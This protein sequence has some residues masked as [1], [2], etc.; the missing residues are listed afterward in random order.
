MKKHVTP[1]TVL[2]ALALFFS[3]AGAG[4]AASSFLVTRLSQISPR[5]RAE[6]RGA[7]GPRGPAGAPGQPGAD[8]K[9]GPAGPQGGAGPAGPPGTAG[10]AGATGLT[11]A[12][13]L[14]LTQDTT[15]SH[16][17]Q[18]TAQSPTMSDD[19]YCPPGDIV[20]YGGYTG[21][22]EI[23]T[24][25]MWLPATNLNGGTYGEGWQLAAQLIPGDSTGSV[26]LNMLCGVS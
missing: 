26:T 6:L 13:Q 1:A 7:A 8:G 19:L 16:T 15:A 9:P 4:L 5:V 17:Y 23:V 24:S 11:G 10:P 18:L 2:T 25:S 22:D 14:T 3:L 21:S 12:A 20:I